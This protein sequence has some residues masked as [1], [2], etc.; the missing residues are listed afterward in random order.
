MSVFGGSERI[1]HSG[2]VP[3]HSQLREILL[4]LIESTGPAHTAVPS[5]RDLGQRFGLSRMTVRQAVDA[6]VAEGRLYRVPGKGTFV[7]PAKFVMPLQLTSFTEDMRAR[8]HV[9]GAVDL[10]RHYVPATD[11]VA[12]ALDL[13]PGDPVVVIERLRTADGEP[14]AIERAHLP[15]ALV[16]GLLEQSL[17]GRSLYAVLQEQYGLVLDHGDQ[18]IEAVAAS[19][20]DAELLHVPRG[21]PV[22]LLV[23][24]SSAGGR[25]VEHVVSTYRGDRYRLRVGLQS[26]AAPPSRS[27]ATPRPGRA[28]GGPR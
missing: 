27:A 18:T 5:E 25:P 24:Y 8:G 20:E 2:P 15:G 4:E 22:L 13:R 14:M 3:K 26:P 28:Q 11:A 6:L 17:Q 16:P 10:G 19:A 12:E 21:H 23:R 7:A 9:P 1:D